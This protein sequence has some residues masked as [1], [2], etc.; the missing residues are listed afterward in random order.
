MQLLQQLVPGLPETSSCSSNGVMLLGWSMGGAA[1]IEAAARLNSFPSAGRQV[2]ALRLVG[3]ITLASQ[4]A[5][6]LKL[7]NAH[8]RVSSLHTALRILACARGH[9]DA[10]ASN[11]AGENT[12]GGGGGYA[13]I[14]IVAM[15]GTHDACVR[16]DCTDKIAALWSA[17]GQTR[18]VVLD[19]DDHAVQSAFERVIEV[20]DEMLPR[21]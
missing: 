9:E 18:K 16:P 4:A 3:I 19:D 15:H 2:E 21:S 11:A 12:R 1:V 10:S 5:G 20:V 6:L 8:G 14:P 13:G 7:G 17:P